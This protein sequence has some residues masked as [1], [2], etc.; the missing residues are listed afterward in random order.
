MPR[1]KTTFGR[2]L[3]ALRARCDGPPPAL[4]FYAPPPSRAQRKPSTDE[5]LARVSAA[6]PRHGRPRGGVLRSA[7][8]ANPVN[9]G[10]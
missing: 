9:I 1:T 2:L 4:R 7:H 10:R 5:N 8:G 3:G 6:K